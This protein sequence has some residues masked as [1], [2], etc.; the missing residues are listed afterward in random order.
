MNRTLSFFF[1]AVSARAAA[2]G[3][4]RTAA[5]AKANER[6]VAPPSCGSL[7]HDVEQLFAGHEPAD[8]FADQ[9]PGQVRRFRRDAGDDG[10]PV[11]Q[12]L[13]LVLGDAE[14]R[15]VRPAEALP[16]FDDG[17]GEEAD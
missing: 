4:A 7:R 5:R 13:D 9:P 15:E 1:G 2:P 12:R 16:V 3:Q 14:M 11:P 6:M 17:V 10:F 8:V